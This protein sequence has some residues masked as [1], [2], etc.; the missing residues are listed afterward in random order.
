[1]PEDHLSEFSCHYQPAIDLSCSRLDRA[2]AFPRFFKCCRRITFR[3]VRQQMAYTSFPLSVSSFRSFAATASI[4]GQ[5]CLISF[6]HSASYSSVLRALSPSLP[7]AQE[8]RRLSDG[9]HSLRQ[10]P[11]LLNS[12]SATPPAML[13]TVSACQSRVLSSSETGL[14]KASCSDHFTHG[15]SDASASCRL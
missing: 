11:S 1:M 9:D 15:E 14:P 6:A 4:R 8:M 13:I 7:L 12:A 3:A 5:C 10:S 2:A